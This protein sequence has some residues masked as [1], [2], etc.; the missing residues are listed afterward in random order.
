MKKGGIGGTERAVES[1]AEDAVDGVLD[2]FTAAFLAFGQGRVRLGA[3]IAQL[4]FL[5]GTLE[6]NGKTSKA[7]LQN[8]VI[9]A[10]LDER[11]GGIVRENSRDQEKWNFASAGTNAM[12]CIETGPARQGIGGENRVKR[13]RK[14]GR[15]ELFAAGDHRRFEREASD[16]KFPDNPVDILKIV[17]DDQDRKRKR[18]CA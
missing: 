9:D 12:E 18:W 5:K 4:F 2:E 7:V 16:F 3:D 15:F 11:G 6:R 17:F 8:I 1:D 14:E 10:L 13:S